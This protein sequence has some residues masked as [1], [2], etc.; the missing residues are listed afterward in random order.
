MTA[1]NRITNI[2]FQTPLGMLE[3][4]NAQFKESVK[5][6]DASEDFIEWTNSS[7]T[8]KHIL[9]LSLVR[10]YKGQLGKA[11]IVSTLRTKETSSSHR[12]SSSRRISG[13]T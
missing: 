12:Q 6:A 3:R 4:E 7:S 10:H 2:T 8:R 9:C 11:I 13:R 1:A 5:K